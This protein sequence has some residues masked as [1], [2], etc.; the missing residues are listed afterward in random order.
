MIEVL[1]IAALAVGGSDDPTPY[2]VDSSGV[3]LPV[4]EVF[5]EGWHVNIKTPD[6]DYDVHFEGKCVER[7]DA[8]C[9]GT[10]HDLAQ[11]IGRSF[12]PWSAFGVGCTVVEWVQ[13]S[14][15]N[16][17]WGEG[18]QPGVETCPDVVEPVVRETAGERFTCE[19]WEYWTLVE[20]FVDGEW[21]PVSSAS[22]L[23]PTSEGERVARGCV[24]GEVDVQLP[25]TTTLAETGDRVTVV[26][27]VMAFFLLVA[28]VVVFWF[29][30]KVGR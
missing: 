28:G 8:E 3:T 30:R 10:R 19:M 26:G 14:A 29:S 25:T 1:L 16:E 17:H 22:S 24:S 7:T 2:T 20:E 9:E 6:G 27:L 11:F 15:Y 12:I 23:F 5:G 13:V 21:V 4:G 18:G